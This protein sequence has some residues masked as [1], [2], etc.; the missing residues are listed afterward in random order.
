MLTVVVELFGSQ[1]VDL[2]LGENHI[3]LAW[4]NT[5]SRGHYFLLIERNSLEFNTLRV[6]KL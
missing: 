5:L 6:L 2:E 3:E 1:K 4:N